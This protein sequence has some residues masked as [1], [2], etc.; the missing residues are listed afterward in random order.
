M[1]I[2]GYKRAEEVEN[3][4]VLTICHALVAFP[5]QRLAQIIVNAIPIELENNLFHLYDEDIIKYL[6]EYIQK[7]GSKESNVT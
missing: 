6:K 3:E 5:D 4:L 2:K 1:A 7:Y